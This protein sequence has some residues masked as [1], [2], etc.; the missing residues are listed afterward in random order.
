M[1]MYFS[2]VC[3]FLYVVIADIFLLIKLINREYIK[4]KLIY[5]KKL[6]EYN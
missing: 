5:T 2:F 1:V 3:L 4:E 6:K